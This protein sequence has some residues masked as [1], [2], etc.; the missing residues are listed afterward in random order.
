MRHELPRTLAPVRVALLA[1]L[2][3]AACRD[4][5]ARYSGQPQHEPECG[6]GVRDDGEDC[7]G[8]SMGDATCTS[9]G[10]EA[11]T[12]T[13]AADCKYS[14]ALCVRRCGNGVLDLDEACDGAL[15]VPACTTWGFNE[16]T[17]ECAIST[18]PCLATPPFSTAPEAAMAYGGPAILGDMSPAGPG[19]LIVGVASRDRVELIAWANAAGFVPSTS[20]KI[21]PLDRT[22]R[23]PEILDANADGVTDL[24]T[25]NADGTFDLLLGGA[26]S[27]TLQTL[28]AGCAGATFIPSNGRIETHAIAVGCDALY[29]L[30]SAGV[31][32]SPAPALVA[33]GPGPIWAD[34]TALHFADGGSFALPVGVT[35]INAGDL[36]GDGD[37]DAAAITANGV[38][39]FENTGTGFA[40]HTTF[41]GTAPG[42]LRVIDVDGDRVV[43]VLWADGEDLVVRRNNGGWS[44]IEKRTAMGSG[45][46]RSLALGDAEGDGDLDV[47]VTFSAGG[48]AT[49]T[50]VF[51]NRVR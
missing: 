20:R 51:L 31:T 50:R 4:S 48:E 14:T 22:P 45:P 21:S 6:D 44:F 26:T 8:S 30:S 19:D 42:A 46:R 36:D 27:Y 35:A 34:A 7:D 25:I 32:T 24:A 10:F 11:G 5:G 40:P 43:D 33:A 9:L 49:V 15:G 12:V 28:D 3:L 18:A 41:T 1:L 37:E 2:V 38:E 13:C 23:L 16:C 29:F 17:S 39:L 47:A